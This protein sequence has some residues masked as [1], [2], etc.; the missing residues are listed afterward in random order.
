MATYTRQE[1]IA[2][3]ENLDGINSDVVNFSLPHGSITVVGSEYERVKAAY[4]PDKHG[5]PGGWFI[6]KSTAHDEREMVIHYSNGE[7]ENIP[8]NETLSRRAAIEIVIYAVEHGNLPDYLTW[9][10]HR[11]F[12]PVSDTGSP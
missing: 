6:D 10:E 4:L 7:V 8:L 12:V 5:N 11:I 1:I 3:I 9:S 2:L